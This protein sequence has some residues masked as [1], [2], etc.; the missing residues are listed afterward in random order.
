MTRILAMLTLCTTALAQAPMPPA[1]PMR[2]APKPVLQSPKATEFTKSL[3][4]VPATTN[5]ALAWNWTNKPIAGFLINQGQASGTYTQAVFVAYHAARGYTN[6]VRCPITGTNYF[7][8]MATNAGQVSG[9]APEVQLPRKPQPR[10]VHTWTGAL[11]LQTKPTLGSKTWV[12][13][14]NPFSITN[15]VGAPMGFLR[16]V[17]SL[18]DPVY[19]RTVLP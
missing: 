19:T 15:G 16:N 12:N 5:I 9:P 8:C 6:S 10:I 11:G 13:C 17:G 14:A 3:A 4:V 18:S 1:V 7:T 2:T